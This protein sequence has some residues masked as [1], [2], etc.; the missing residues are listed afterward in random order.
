[1]SK[2][3]FLKEL[4]EIIEDRLYI[5]DS[6]DD[7]NDEVSQNTWSI[8]MGQELA[9]ELT[10]EDLKLFFNQF[11]NNRKEQIL[12]NSDHN[13]IFYVWF[14]WQSARLRFNLISDFHN[15]LPF[16]GK[17]KVIENIEPILNKFLQF[18]YHD[19]F[20]IV[21]IEEEVAEDDVN[22]ELFDVYSVIITNS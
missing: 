8:S 16:G 18:P 2:E 3:D 17:Y 21:E 19:G 1:M 11:Q 22:I 4:D 20:P 6:I 5:G 7:L 12:K 15:K 13:M 10:T 14:D 9:N